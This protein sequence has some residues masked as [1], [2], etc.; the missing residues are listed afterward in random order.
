MSLPS[1]FHDLTPIP[2]DDGSNT[3]C[4]IDYTAEFI[5]AMDYFRAVIKAD[6]C[7]ERA[8]KLTGLCLKMNPANYTVWHFRRRC[9]QALH[10]AKHPD[11]KCTFDPEDVKNDLQLAAQLGGANP[12]NYQIWYHRRALLDPGLIQPRDDDSTDDDSSKLSTIQMELHYVAGVLDE[13]AKN[14]H[15]WSHR[16]WIIMTL[17]TSATLWSNEKQ[18]THSLLERDCRNNSAWNQRWFVVH[19]G[20]KDPLSGEECREEAEY[21]LESVGGDPYN[22]SPWRYL[23]GVL[24]ERVKVLTREGGDIGE[25]IDGYLTKIEDTKQKLSS[26]VEN[27]NDCYNLT[28]AYIDLLQMKGDQNSLSQ[29][30]DFARELS[31]LY[32]TIRAKYWNMRE[33]ELRA[34]VTTC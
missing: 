23:I 15:A 6:E 2:Q 30:A 17:P 16:Q 29:A 8:L 7:S 20:S 18:Y 4:A 26:K 5:E 3:I 10:K 34:A 19:R 33:E 28:S 27:P 22:E 9:L 25:F 1:L 24:R 21:A 12:K 31:S 32:D 11:T 14:Y 13:D